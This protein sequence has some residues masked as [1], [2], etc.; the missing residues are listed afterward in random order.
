MGK[1]VNAAFEE[2]RL[3]ACRRRVPIVPK[4]KKCQEIEN[5]FSAV[6]NACFFRS[7]HFRW[8]GQSVLS[9]ASNCPHLCLIK[10]QSVFPPHLILRHIMTYD[11]MRTGSLWIQRRALTRTAFERVRTDVV[12]GSP[13]AN[14]SGVGICRVMAHHPEREMAY[15]CPHISAWLST[16]INGRLRFEFEKSSIDEETMR[17]HFPWLLFQVAEPYVVP[18]PLL[19][20]RTIAQRTIRPGIYRVW[21]S[22]THLIVEF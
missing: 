4:F 8:D 11:A 5:Q 9:T 17:I 21:D 1:K 7:K 19:R 16:T 2:K 10:R 20:H 15:S 12:L 18:Y 22:G 3:P 6:L 14:C 13:S